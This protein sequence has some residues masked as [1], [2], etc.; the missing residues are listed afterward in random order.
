MV[1]SLKTR[2]ISGS[3]RRQEV[4]IVRTARFVIR[5]TPLIAIP[6]EARV[7]ERISWTKSSD[8]RAERFPFELRARVVRLCT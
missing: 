4:S 1:R 6:V 8:P 5:M 3:R 7:D 2:T